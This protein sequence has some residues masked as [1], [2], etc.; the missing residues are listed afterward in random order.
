VGTSFRMTLRARGGSGVFVW[1][2]VAG[3]LPL[4]LRLRDDGSIVGTPRFAGSYRFVAR[5]TDTEARSLRWPV[6]LVVAPRLRVRTQQLAPAK[7]GRFYSA[8]LTTAGGVRPTVWKLRRGRLPH[9]IRLVPAL[10][11]FTGTPSEAGTHRVAVEVID[12]LNVRSTRAFAIVVST[13]LRKE[14][15]ARNGSHEGAGT[16]PVPPN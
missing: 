15:G 2:L 3:R 10:G 11:R 9:G 1:A 16:R 14:S 6:T 5:A 7:V 8:E 12:G 13:S 4:G